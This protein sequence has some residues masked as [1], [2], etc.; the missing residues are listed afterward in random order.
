ME[1]AVKDQYF[2]DVNDYRKYGLLRALGGGGKVSTMV[3]WALTRGDGRSDGGRTSYLRDPGGWEAY[4]PALYSHLRKQVVVNGNRSVRAAECPSVLPNCAFFSEILPA[5]PEARDQYFE[6]L[7][8]RSEGKVLLFLDPDNGI[9]VKSAPRG[10]PASH[11]Y[12]YPC[13]LERTYKAGLTVLVYQHFPRAARAPYIRKRVLEL[14][15]VLGVRRIVTF[16]TSHVV[17]LLVPQEKHWPLLNEAFEDVASRWGGQISVALHS[18]KADGKVSM[19]AV[20]LPRRA[21][22]G[23]QRTLPTSAA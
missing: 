8:E 4:D 3:C 18:I 22:T 10:T 5:D 11:K 12:V 19:R 14:N 6:R 1:V 21:P 20:A 9:A 16:S 15:R 23:C 17:F 7:L 13:E 2:G